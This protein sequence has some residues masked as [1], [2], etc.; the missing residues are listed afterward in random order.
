MSTVEKLTKL[1]ENEELLKDFNDK[2]DDLKTLEKGLEKLSV[3]KKKGYTIP[4]ID[5]I[6]I[7]LYRNTPP[8]AR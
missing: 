8:K 4:P 7:N 2:Y 1:F 6:G 3:T 5:T